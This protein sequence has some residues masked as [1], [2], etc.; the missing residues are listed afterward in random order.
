MP[1]SN[2]YFQIRKKNSATMK[3][4]K[5]NWNKYSFNHDQKAVFSGYFI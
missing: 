4:F 2:T 3:D 5:L 1:F